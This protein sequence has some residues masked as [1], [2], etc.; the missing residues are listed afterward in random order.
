MRPLELD[1]TAFRSYDRAT[2]DLRPHELV[3]ISGDTGAGKTSLL[4]AVSFALF[5]QTPEKARPGDLLTLGRTHG[6]V[7]L[8]FAAKGEV[9][10]VS[11]RYGPDA[12]EPS[13]VLERLDG[14]GGP[15]VETTG[16]EE[17]V[18]AALGRLVGMSFR[19]FTSAVLLAQGRFAEFLGAQP[20]DR[21]AILREL[22]N[23][24]SL[25]GA[26]L[27]AGRAQASAEGE[28]EAYERSVGRLAAHGPGER[29]AAARAGREASARHAAAQRLVPLARATDG[30]AEAAASARAR[31]A[32]ARAA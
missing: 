5:G 3:V 7:R 6:E 2:V 25:E 32:S 16:G 17:A 18:Q 27:A 9:W 4:D 24:A 31:A 29:S 23:V 1:L 30:H 22:F 26:R 10:R 21:D 12:P 11:R 19:A 20:R 8:T 28:A 14:D 13:H 15:A